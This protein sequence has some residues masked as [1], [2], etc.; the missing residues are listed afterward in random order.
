MLAKPKTN[1]SVLDDRTGKL[2]VEASTFVTSSDNATDSAKAPKHLVYDLCN[3]IVQKGKN[4]KR[5]Q[6]L[7]AVT[8]ERKIRQVFSNY[9]TIL[10]AIQGNQMLCFPLSCHSNPF[11]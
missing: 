8:A 5:M 1:T 11:L 7:S 2:F 4:W 9:P 10:S 3:W 6:E